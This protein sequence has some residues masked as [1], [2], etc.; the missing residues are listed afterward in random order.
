MLTGKVPFTGTTIQVMGQ[1]LHAPLPLERLKNIPEPAV[2]FLKHMLE[3][4]GWRV[5]RWLG[6]GVALLAVISGI[7]F[8]FLAS[9]SRPALATTKSIAV[10]SEVSP[11]LK[12]ISCPS[13]P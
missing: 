1:H 7:G 5:A 4:G 9:K 10:T 6:I 12:V 11:S 8:Y 2:V 13:W 3:K